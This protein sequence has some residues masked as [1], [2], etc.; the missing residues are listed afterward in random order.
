[1]MKKR[2]EPMSRIRKMRI[3]GPGE[4]AERKEARIIMNLRAPH[5]LKN[6][7]STT[8][9]CIASGIKLSAYANQTIN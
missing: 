9:P 8:S 1:M 4:A 7:C 6:H 2:M 3:E 5:V